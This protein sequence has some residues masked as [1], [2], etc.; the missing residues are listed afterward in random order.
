V[1]ISR[2]RVATPAVQMELRAPPLT[3]PI[4]HRGAMRVLL[5]SHDTFGLG[6]LRRARTI[7]AALT[8]A[9]PEASALILTGSPVAGRFTFPERVDHIRLPGVIKRPDGSYSAEALGLDID[10]TT[11]LRAGLIE[12]AAERFAPDLVIVDKEPTGF[13]GEMMP[14]LEL[15]RRRGDARIVLGLRDI[16]DT[17]TVV[18]EEWARKGALPAIA[19]H[20][21]EIWVYGDRRIFDPTEDVGLPEAVR[22]RTVWTGY[23]RRSDT[24]TAEPL[25][26]ALC[27]G[28]P[29]RRRRRRRAGRSGA[30]RLRD[31]TPTSRPRPSSSTDPSL[32]ASAAPS[33]RNGS[34][35][36]PRASPRSV[37]TAGW[38]A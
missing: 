15:L 26:P 33:S 32:P 19:A 14:T 29:G 2:E 13:R 36:L 21:D 10:E 9:F 23:L 3:A 34:P 6:H 8:E 20:Y 37:S 27:A 31:T 25:A 30:L 18:A 38:R 1:R 11:W 12:R 35:A 24:G 16:L 28:H 17:P 22:A 7:A 4:V 5:Y